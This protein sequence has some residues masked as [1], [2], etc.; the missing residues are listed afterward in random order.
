MWR[1]QEGGPGGGSSRPS[2]P[3]PDSF[4]PPR[5]D[6]IPPTDYPIT[7][8]LG[9]TFLVAERVILRLLFTSLCRSPL[10]R[11]GNPINDYATACLPFGPYFALHAR[12]KFIFEDGRLKY[13]DADI[14]RLTS[15]EGLAEPSIV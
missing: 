5:L 10:P 1:S 4:L 7:P 13:S 2:T 3:T 8:S 11:T 6:R 15:R 9:S 12:F 14:L